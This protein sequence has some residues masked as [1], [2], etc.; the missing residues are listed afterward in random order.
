MAPTDI[1][2][3]LTI[4]K[5]REETGT[6]TA[7]SPDWA[8]V[9]A[10]IGLTLF[11]LIFVFS[12]SFAVGQRV[13]GDP[14]YFAIR[15]LAGA[16]IG[17]V[18]FILFSYLDYRRLRAWSPLFMIIAI[19]GLMAVLVPGIGVEQNGARRWQLGLLPEGKRSAM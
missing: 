8:L 2:R 5:R 14:Q 9:T 12:S 10:I 13:F 19:L 7:G 18:A 16:G 1:S 3:K 6:A 15:Q 11:G 17:L 4:G